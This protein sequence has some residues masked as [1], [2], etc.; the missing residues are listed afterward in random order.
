MQLSLLS[1]C[2]EPLLLSSWVSWP[3]CWLPCRFL[4]G[5]PISPLPP[6][7]RLRQGPLS[8]FCLSDVSILPGSL[9]GPA[10]VWGTSGWTGRVV[11]PANTPFCHPWCPGPGVPQTSLAEF[12]VEAVP[13]AS[14][15]EMEAAGQ[16]TSQAAL[17]TRI[18]KS[19]QREP[20]SPS[21]L[22]KHSPVLGFAWVSLPV[23]VAKE[24]LFYYLCT[25]GELEKARCK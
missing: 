21:P 8:H 3:G 10:E 22:V 11:L 9:K 19:S 2:R 6:A 17:L 23:C 24:W 7:P 5:C 20:K 15:D 13:P 18:P 16:V 14:L 25:W 12:W 1:A 4:L